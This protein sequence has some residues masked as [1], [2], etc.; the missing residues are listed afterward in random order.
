MAVAL[1]RLKDTIKQAAK[2]VTNAA[3]E[4]FTDGLRFAQLD[5]GIQF[6]I[7][8]YDDSIEPQELSQSVDD[9]P[10]TVQTSRSTERPAATSQAQTYG[11]S[12][13]SEVVY[14]G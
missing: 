6:T 4:C 12:S 13:R 10:E 11:R 1:S 5:D 8:V 14:S 9:T 2:A 7:Q 3:E